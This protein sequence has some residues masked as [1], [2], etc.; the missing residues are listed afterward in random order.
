M[1]TLR[2]GS[3][4]FLQHYDEVE[5]KLTLITNKVNISHKPNMAQ[6]L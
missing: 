6:A 4:T 5:K 2:Q 3:L 1:S